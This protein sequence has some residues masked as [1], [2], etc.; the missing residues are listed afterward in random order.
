MEILVIAFIL[1]VGFAGRSAWD[2]VQRTRKAAASGRQKAVARAYGKALPKHKVKATARRHALGWWLRE[3]GNGFP[4][5]RTGWHAGWIAHRTEYLQHAGHREEARTRHAEAQATAA[6]TVRDH[7]QRRAA[8]RA[9]RDAILRQLQDSPPEGKGRQAVREAAGAV[10][11]PFVPRERPHAPLPAETVGKGKEQP[12]PGP[13]AQLGDSDSAPRLSDWVRPGDPLCESCGG[14]GGLP[15]GQCA[16][17]L[18]CGI[19]PGSPESPVVDGAICSACGQSALP[20]DP[21]VQDGND[22][23]HRSHITDDIARRQDALGVNNV[24]ADAA[25][26]PT[27][28]IATEGEHVTT[29]I[30]QGALEPSGESLGYFHDD[31]D[32]LKATAPTATKGA[33]V[34]ASTAETTYDQQIAAA[35]A[36]ISES[37]HEIARLRTRRITQQVENLASLGLDSGSLGRAA[38][39]D[40]SLR[41]Q[42][43]Q[44]QET[45]DRAQAFRDGLVRDHGAGNEYHQAAPGGGAEKAFFGG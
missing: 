3:A 36:I 37:E 33:P 7:A 30:D 41:A 19:G 39:I 26:N 38:E 45:L 42:E 16:E 35:N 4:V 5:T 32:A 21:V 25:R 1:G 24:S 29:G 31:G 12:E 34:T 27:D 8:A 40:D 17:C 14:T 11:L 28:P 43:K 20:G 22:L 44:A 10:V 13:Y 23:T 15:G 18:G 9:R 6:E 2:H